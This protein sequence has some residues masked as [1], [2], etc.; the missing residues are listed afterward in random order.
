MNA[1]DH[2]SMT[3]GVL[4]ALSCIESRARPCGTRDLTT[5]LFQGSVVS[6]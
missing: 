4:N 5:G 1:F 6:S 3:T 2:G